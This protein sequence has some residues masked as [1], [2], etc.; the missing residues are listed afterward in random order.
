MRDVSVFGVPSDLSGLN[1]P[2]KRDILLYYSFLGECAI[3]KSEMF[4]YRSST[5]LVTDKL[6]H[7][8]SELDLE[9]IQKKSII[10][11]LNNFLEKYRIQDRHK[12]RMMSSF[13]AFEETTKE[14]FYI[15]RCQCDL[16]ADLC[17]CGL[18]P[19]RLKEFMKDQHNERKLTIPEYA[20][21]IEDITI[22]YG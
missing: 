11:K 17:S 12:T 16:K 20:I 3:T 18:I 15:G 2:T 13:T 5:P 8:W 21:E 19:E 7:I 10:N 14:I 22:F 9:T 4:S 1:L 6:I